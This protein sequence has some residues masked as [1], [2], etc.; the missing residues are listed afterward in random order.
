MKLI[1]LHG[2]GQKASSWNKT[3]SYMK[4]SS[5][6][7]ILCPELSELLNG[8]PV[9]YAELCASFAEYCSHIE[10]KV[11][12]CGLSLGGIIGLEYALHYPEKVRSL[13][14]IGTPH[15]VPKAAFAFQNLIFRFLPDSAFKDMAFDKRDTFMLGKSMSS[16]DFSGR[17]NNISC[18][19]LIICGGKD[20][21]NINSARYFSERM[22]SSKIKILDNVGHIVNEEAPEKLAFELEQFYDSISEDMETKTR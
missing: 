15:T 14:L 22:S 3:I 11:D 8:K 12:I 13:V 6:R 1:L 21:A 4:D 16:L 20:K 5:G 7:E 17:V 19:V 10:G 2:S 18:P 9:G